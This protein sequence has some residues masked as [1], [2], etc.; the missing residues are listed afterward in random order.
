MYWAQALTSQGENAD[1]KVL[2][3]PIAEALAS[4]ESIILEELLAAQGRPVDIGGYYKPDEQM[5]TNA[6]RPS[7]TLNA[8][9][10]GI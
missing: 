8:I 6:M 4:N 10:E 2:F 1:L 9:L 5:T 7:T 3:T